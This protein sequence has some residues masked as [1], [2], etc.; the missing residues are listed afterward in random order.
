MKNGVKCA[1]ADKN[2]HQSVPM[3]KKNH[4]LLVVTM[5]KSCT[6]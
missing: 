2:D 5:F 4:D 1:Y 3:I 6:D